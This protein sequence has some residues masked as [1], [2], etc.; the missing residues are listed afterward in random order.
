MCTTSFNRSESQYKEK[1]MPIRIV[2]EEKWN[3]KPFVFV[4]KNGGGQQS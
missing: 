1:K 3:K 2:R 4:R